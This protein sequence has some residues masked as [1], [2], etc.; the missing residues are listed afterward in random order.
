MRGPFTTAIFLITVH[1]ERSLMGLA[2]TRPAQ[3]QS[4][5]SPS[6]DPGVDADD[7]SDHFTVTNP[8][9]LVGRIIR[10]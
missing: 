4:S 9:G 10:V 3:S 2:A 5:R 7:V 8:P 1:H 6:A